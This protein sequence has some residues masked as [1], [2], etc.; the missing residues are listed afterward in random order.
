MTNERTAAE[1]LRSVL[2][3]MTK[4][5]WTIEA[6]GNIRSAAVVRYGPGPCDIFQPGIPN[7]EAIVTLVNCAE[8]IVALVSAV[9]RLEQEFA[10]LDNADGRTFDALWEALDALTAKLKEQTKA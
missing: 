7:D 5:P 8:E 1:M 9:K 6:F 4:R 10:E 3:G 2:E